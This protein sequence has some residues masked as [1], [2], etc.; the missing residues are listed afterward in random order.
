MLQLFVPQPD[1]SGKVS[2]KTGKI[3]YEL[4]NQK[5]W[6]SDKNKPEYQS[7]DESRESY[8]DDDDDEFNHIPYFW[9]ISITA[10]KSLSEA[11]KRV[12]FTL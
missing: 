7:D 6:D 5:E 8:N 1:S 12:A 4:K 2:Y 3:P 10:R 11:A 9:T